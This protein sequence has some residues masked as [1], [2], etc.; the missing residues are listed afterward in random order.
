[1]ELIGFVKSPKK[2]KKYRAILND[3]T[4]SKYVD[5]G[6][7][8]YQHYEDKIGLYSYL[9]HLDKKRR[10]NYRARHSAILTKDGVPA[11]KVP[12]T[13]AFFSWYYLW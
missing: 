2:Y 11:Y 12:Y 5:F 13:P 7:T 6:D 10:A 4:R 9:D 1:M 8:R 3:G